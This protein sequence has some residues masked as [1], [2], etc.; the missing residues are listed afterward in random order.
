MGTRATV[1]RLLDIAT[2]FAN[3]VGSILIVILVVLMAADIAGRNLAGAP[4]SGVP[5]LITLS[6]VAI[7]FLQA[8][9]AFKEGRIVRTEAAISA[10][11]ARAPR[12]A[13]VVELVFDLLGFAIISVLVWAH[14]PILKQSWIGD[15]YIGSVGSFI[16]PT[17]PT[18]LMLMIGAVLMALQ[19]IAR[20]VRRLSGEHVA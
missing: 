7:V 15:E 20:I 5:E 9:Q 12:V 3:V 14:W 17:W 11:T 6:I 1:F 4:V 10:L 19:F 18:K 2:Q 13:A 8:P 16:A